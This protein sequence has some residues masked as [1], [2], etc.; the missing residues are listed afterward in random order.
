MYYLQNKDNYIVNTRSDIKGN[1]GKKTPTFPL[2]ILDY[3]DLYD[4]S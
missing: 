3:V 2:I 4:K 1:V